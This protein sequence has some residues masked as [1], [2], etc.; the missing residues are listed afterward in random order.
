MGPPPPSF[1]V[2]LLSL[3]LSLSLSLPFSLFVVPPRSAKCKHTDQVQKTKFITMKHGVEQFTGP[4]DKTHTC[5]L[6]IFSPSTALQ[7]HLRPHPLWL[8]PSRIT[9]QCGFAC[10]AVYY[11]AKGTTRPCLEIPHTTSRSFGWRLLA[12]FIHNRTSFFI[13]IAHLCF[14]MELFDIIRPFNTLMQ[15]GERAGEVTVS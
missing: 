3:Q 10:H 4:W 11:G 2:C 14:S 9:S 12:R 15:T 8:S 13:F 6:T 5:I 1:S 7:V